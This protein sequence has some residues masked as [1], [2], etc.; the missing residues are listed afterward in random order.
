M[1]ILLAFPKRF[2]IQ[3]TFFLLQNPLLGNFFR[4]RIY[5]G[6]LK[7]ICT[8]GLNC[9]SCP[10]AIT[11]CPLGAM[12]LFIGGVKHSI[13]LFV[14]G[15]LLAAGVVFGRFICGYVCPFGLFQDLLYKIKTPKLKL[16]LKYARYIK[17][18][19]LMLFVFVLPY[20][21]RCELSGLGSPWFCEY[22]CPAGTIFGAA[23]LLAVNEFL[24]SVLGWRFILKASIAVVIIIASVF[25][26]RIFCRVLCPLGAIYALFNKFAVFRMR[27]DE[28]KCTSCGNCREACQILIDPAKQPNSPECVRCRGCAMAC[29]EKALR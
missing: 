23:P 10:A 15:F 18:I 13:S 7:Q 11:S 9:Y 5:Q 21:I 19:I 29:K 28:D 22:I 4:G 20:V 12:Q 6:G 1:K 3:I 16:R 8:P 26:F 2:L 25:I 14:T 24:R 27:C 17:Y